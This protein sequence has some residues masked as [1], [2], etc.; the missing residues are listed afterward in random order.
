[1]D[2]LQF[3]IPSRIVLGKG[4][5][6]RLGGLAENYGARALLVPDSILTDT[7]LPGRISDILQR[8][9]ISLIHAAGIES[10]S[11]HDAVA[12]V[13]SLAKASRSQ[14]IIGLGGI[15]TLSVAKCASALAGGDRLVDD[16]MDGFPV[17]SP[18]VTYLEIPTTCRNP[19][20]LNNNLLLLDSRSR[21]ARLL[22]IPGLFPD[23]VILDPS[24]TET[25]PEKYVLSTLL[26]TFLYALEGY[27]SLKNNF[28]SE[29][30]FL[31]SI[32]L[33][34]SALRMLGDPQYAD[35]FRDKACQAGI[36]AA[37][38]LSMSRL[39][40]GAGLAFALS[41]RYG[42]PKS[43]A[44]SMM[45]PTVL[46]YGVLAAPDKLARIAVILEA[47]V[48]GLKTA[49]AAW[50]AVEIMR[51]RLGARIGELR[52]P[53]LRIKKDEMADTAEFVHT[54]PMI[55]DMPG[56]LGVKDLQ[57]MIRRAL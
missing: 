47:D 16:L 27:L 32:A 22:E 57:D 39:G 30:Q 3:S 41:G 20:M 26:D 49:E 33:V 54:Y 14:M 52:I 4:V 21:R 19:F 17:T 12:E 38:G 18:R 50:K 5:L 24:L 53:N 51:D 36:C 23:A 11:F 35:E 56:S 2:E 31:K 10:D 13:V 40:A 15:R 9:G 37:V 45:I 25:L 43:L 44:A 8:K 28:L 46:E 34:D 6:G 55:K 7:V 1:M 42:V 29:S 48:R